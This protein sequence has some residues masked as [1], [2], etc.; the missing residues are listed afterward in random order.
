MARYL[1]LWELDETKVPLDPGDRAAAWS[2]MLDMVESDMKTG[3]LKDWAAHAGALRGYSV[4]EG[5][6]FEVATNCQ[7]YIPYVRFTVHPLTSL[8]EMRQML[9]DMPK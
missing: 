4:A 9:Q 7:K 8:A 3:R 1:V 2:P 6:E 5:S